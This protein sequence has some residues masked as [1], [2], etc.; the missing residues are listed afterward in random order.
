MEFFEG[1][2]SFFRCGDGKACDEETRAKHEWLHA[3]F[4]AGSMNGVNTSERWSAFD[5]D[6][7]ASAFEDRDEVFLNVVG[8]VE[9][10]EGGL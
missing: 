6:L 9:M 8:D 10:I 1:V 2:E 5:D 7:L 3:T 4:I